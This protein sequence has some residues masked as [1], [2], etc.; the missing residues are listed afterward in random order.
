MVELDASQAGA[1][2]WKFS[3]AGMTTGGL[4]VKFDGKEVWSKPSVAGTAASFDTWTFFWENQ[5]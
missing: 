4:S 3:V 2:E 5:K 1:G